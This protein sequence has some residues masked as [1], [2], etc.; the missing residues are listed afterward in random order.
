[1][2]S[3][4]C[5]TTEGFG[6]SLCHLA[7]RGWNALVLPRPGMR[8]HESHCRVGCRSV[9]IKDWAPALGLGSELEKAHVYPVNWRPFNWVLEWPSNQKNKQTEAITLTSSWAMRGC[10]LCLRGKSATRCS[11]E[12][13][14]WKEEGRTWKEIQKTLM[15]S[16]YNQ[17]KAWHLSA[18]KILCLH[19]EAALWGKETGTWGGKERNKHVGCSFFQVG[20]KHRTSCR[21]LYLC[22]YVAYL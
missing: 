12:A 20:G 7:T 22:I 5:G 18:A 15:Q 8:M 21:S 9:Y 11:G 16:L 10:F 6:E 19:E 2:S 17:G 14:L 4:Y 1:M 13:S 3:C